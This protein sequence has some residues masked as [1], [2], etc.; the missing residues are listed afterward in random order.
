MAVESIPL[1]EVEV[2][3]VR[4]EEEVRWNALLCTHHY[5]GFRNL[6]GQCLRHVDVQ[7]DRWLAPLGWRAA[8]QHCAA[9]DR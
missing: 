4:R 7:G 5:L 3:V 6:C 2:R 9:R 1:R 8:A